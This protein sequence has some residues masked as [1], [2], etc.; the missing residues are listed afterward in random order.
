MGSFFK[1][2]RIVSQ[3][4]NSLNIAS[5]SK[6]DVRLNKF[7]TKINAIL[8]LD[9][10]IFLLQDIRAA[11]FG[12]T[13]KRY[14]ANNQYTNYNVKFNSDKSSRGVAIGYKSSLNIKILDEFQDINQNIL[15]LKINLN[16]KEIVIG[17]IYG[18]I[19]TNCPNFID[20][21]SNKIKEFGS[22]DFIIGGDF[23]A[24]TNNKLPSQNIELLNM[25][26]IP[27]PI[28]SNKICQKIMGGGIS[29]SFQ[30]TSP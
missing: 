24:I 20:T 7:Q 13:F 15:L 18:P 2:I 6:T 8:S 25:Q 30:E 9:P 26:N 5:N 17:S 27:N 1:N 23:N 22:D 4:V 14:L 12:K 29:G 10:D 16:N 11:K 21:I 19:Q 3:N 28:H